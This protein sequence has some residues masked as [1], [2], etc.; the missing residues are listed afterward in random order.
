MLKNITFEKK[1][2]INSN[3][4]VWLGLKIVTISI[5]I[6]F[7]GAFFIALDIVAFGKALVIIGLIGGFIGMAT[8]FTLII[9]RFIKSRKEKNI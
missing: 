2:G 1:L 9:L 4:K 7:T 6:T 5:L 3:E 8:H